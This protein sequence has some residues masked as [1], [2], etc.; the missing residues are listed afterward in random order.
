MKSKM[1]IIKDLRKEWEGLGKMI[2]GTVN[3]STSVSVGS[4][5]TAPNTYYQSLTFLF[6]FEFQSLLRDFYAFDCS[7]QA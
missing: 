5:P 3:P 2:R 1:S 7:K 4:S 6:S